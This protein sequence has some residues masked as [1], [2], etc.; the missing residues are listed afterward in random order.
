MTCSEV[1][2]VE[3]RVHLWF[4]AELCHELTCDEFI[5][6]SYEEFTRGRLFPQ[7][8]QCLEGCDFHPEVK[9]H[10]HLWFPA[11][12]CHEL[13]RDE[14]ATESY[15]EFTR[16]RLFLQVFKCLECCDLHPEVETHN[17]A[18]L[19]SSRSLHSWY[20]ASVM[21]MEISMFSRPN[22]VI[23]AYVMNSPQKAMKSSP[24][25]DFFHGS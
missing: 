2:E 14:L 22:F 24:E 15:E 19:V 5:T 18:S 9:T 4:P 11:E 21:S 6:E 23:N 12:L 20:S 13:I 16:G 8:I 10:V 3:T 17:Y 7:I 1:V 25:E